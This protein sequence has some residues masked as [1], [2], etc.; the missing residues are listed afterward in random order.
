MTRT[1]AVLANPESGKGRGGSAAPQVV[2]GL[3]ERGFSVEVL[4]GAD[5]DE[6]LRLG[7]AAVASGVDALIAVGGDGTVNLAVQCVAETGTAL[8]IV[9]VGTGNDNARLLG[10]PV[11]DPAG[12]VGVIAEGA[13]RAID[14]AQVQCDSGESLWFLGVLS[15]G[16]DSVVNE[17]ANAMSWPTGEARYVVALL[18][19]LGPFRPVEFTVTIDGIPMI[20]RGM[21]AAIGNGVSY[22]GGMR[23]C[24]GALV[25]DGL[26]TMTWLHAVSKFEFLRTFPKV[27]RG[28]HLAHPSITQH[29]GRHIRLEA[30]DQVAYADGERVGPLPIDVVVHPGQ[31]HVLLPRGSEVGAAVPH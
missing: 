30:V 21:L 14:V 25:D 29:H 5:A 31:L 23:V 10:L 11:K 3:R 1:V 22:G 27:Y 15:S 19:E 16:F 6:A 17:R 13:P 7:K 9:A 4:I 2:A 18:R 12:A 20:D 28:T 8:G 26:L 24:E